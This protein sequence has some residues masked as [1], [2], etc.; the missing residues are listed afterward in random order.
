MALSKIDGDAINGTT[1]QDGVFFLTA[2]TVTTDYTVP[3]LYNALSAGPIEIA[4][5]VTVEISTGSEW[6][7]V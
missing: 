7:I 4:T 2:Q 3:S 5:G 1:A 6:T